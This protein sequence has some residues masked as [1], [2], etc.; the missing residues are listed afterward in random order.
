MKV[1]SFLGISTLTLLIMASGSVYSS[2]YQEH[3][4]NVE[5]WRKTGTSEEQLKAL[6]KV[7]PGTHH[8]MPEIAYRLQSMYWAGKQQ[9]WEFAE[10]QIDSM[11]KMIGRVANARPKRGPSI[12]TFKANVFGELYKAVKTKDFEVFAEAVAITSTECTACHA[13]EGFDYIAIPAVPPKPNNIV[14]D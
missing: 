8:W 14:L 10:Y 2:N 6:V 9:K 11:E 7:T 3:S 13:K 12:D 4:K 5:D 1:K